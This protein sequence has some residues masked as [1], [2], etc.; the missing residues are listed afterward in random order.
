MNVDG[1][2]R[3][4]R[5]WLLC[6]TLQGNAPTHP[7]GG[8]ILW[9]NWQR[10]GDFQDL[11]R[12]TVP[13]QALA[14]LGWSHISPETLTSHVAFVNMFFTTPWLSFDAFVVEPAQTL[15]AVHDFAELQRRALEDFLHAQIAE[16]LRAEPDEP[17]PL[18]LWI[19]G[20]AAGYAS[21][22]AAVA[23]LEDHVLRPAVGRLRPVDKAIAH[24]T[25]GTRGLQLANLLLSAALAAWQDS[26]LNA[27]RRALQNAI[28]TH[29]GWPNLRTTSRP[30][31]TKFNLRLGAP[32]ERSRT[33]TQLP[34]F[35]PL[36]SSRTARAAKASRP[37]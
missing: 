19:D 17:Q 11:L 2:K 33:A 12:Q 5:R 30:E 7:W 23:A 28:A 37:T 26:S 22:K 20:P 14:T 25:S 6:T 8:S 3:G 27:P 36:P 32:T 21:R 15:P 16:R 1:G 35:D 29:L 34:L 24:R 9:L 18:R 4:L 10:R 31:D 13:G